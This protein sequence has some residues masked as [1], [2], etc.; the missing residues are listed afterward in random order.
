MNPVAIKKKKKAASHCHYTVGIASASIRTAKQCSG[1]V[2]MPLFLRFLR[3]SGLWILTTLT[4][5]ESSLKVIEVI[6][7]IKVIKVIKT[8]PI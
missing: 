4:P 8:T 3:F 1:G 5:E 6:K 2:V 7:A